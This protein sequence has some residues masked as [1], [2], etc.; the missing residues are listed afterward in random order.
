M[1]RRGAQ[2][3]PAGDLGMNARTRAAEEWKPVVGWEGVYDV[4]SWG[5]VYSRPRTV[6]RYGRPMLIK[7]RYLSLYVGNHG[8][9]VANLTRDGVS[10]KHLVH[11]LVCRAFHGAPSNE[12]AEVGHRNGKRTDAHARNLRWVTRLENEADKI[13]HRTRPQGEGH[14]AAKLS[15]DEVLWIKASPRRILDRQLAMILGVSRPLVTM[16]RNGSH[17]AV[18]ASLEA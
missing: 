8:Y 12:L 11:R 13:L 9:P 1:V 3:L 5:R 14:Y 2:G 7:G 17:R 4:S 6:Q 10:V 15:D 16:V 18:A